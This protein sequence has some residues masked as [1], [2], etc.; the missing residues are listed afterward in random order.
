MAVLNLVLF[1]A[2]FAVLIVSGGWSVKLLSRVAASFRMKDFVLGFFLVGLGTSLPEI[3]VGITSAFEGNPVISLGDVIGSN[4]VNLTLILGVLVILGRGLRVGRRAAKRDMV[5]MLLISSLPVFLL[6][7]GSLS[8]VEGLALL[9]AFVLY[10]FASMNDGNSFSAEG[11]SRK[12]EKAGLRGVVDLLF[13]AAS[14]AALLVSSD[15]VVRYGVAMATDMGISVMLVGLVAVAFGTSLPEL[16]F[17]VR[18]AAAKKGGMALGNLVGSA[19]VNSTVVLGA[20]SMI[21]PIVADYVL[22]VTSA[23]FM[24]VVM[25]LV[26]AVAER[27][28][29]FSTMNGVTLVVMYFI[30]V[31]AEAL[32]GFAH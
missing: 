11:G 1:A 12:I 32:Q 9:L 5:F 3:F 29:G 19:V 30:F 16:V 8:G 15:F 26:T 22:F 23:T 10:L 6:L 4:V 28:G 18:A 14:L 20:T 21:R 31:I 27:K 13:L 17:S 24:I 25:F 7:D 2:S